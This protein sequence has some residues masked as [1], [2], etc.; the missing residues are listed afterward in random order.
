[1]NDLFLLLAVAVVAILGWAPAVHLYQNKRQ[2]PLAEFSKADLQLAF[3]YAPDERAKVFN[4]G[5]MSRAEFIRLQK[6]NLRLVDEELKRRGA[7]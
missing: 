2:R 6:L 7:A 4:R 3:R 1:M 5:T